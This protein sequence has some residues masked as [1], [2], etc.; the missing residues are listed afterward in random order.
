MPPKV[1]DITTLLLPILTSFS[2]RTSETLLALQIGILPP[3][4][5]Y[6]YVNCQKSQRR[7]MEKRKY[8]LVWVCNVQGSSNRAMPFPHLHPAKK[9]S[10]IVSHTAALISQASKLLSEHA[11]GSSIY[12][13]PFRVLNAWVKRNPGCRLLKPGWLLFRAAG[14]A[15]KV[16]MRAKLFMFCATSN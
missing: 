12:R 4:L 15:V 8:V 11:F 6:S 13:G 9:P 2:F 5:T 10:V 16:E 1:S 7:S 3:Y 14:K